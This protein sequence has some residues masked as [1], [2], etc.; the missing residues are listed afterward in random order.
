MNKKDDVIVKLMEKIQSLEE[1]L[2]Q[3]IQETKEKL[4][5]VQ[6]ICREE[7]TVACAQIT[8]KTQRDMEEQLQLVRQENTQTGLLV[9]TMMNEFQNVVKNE[10][11]DMKRGIK[12]TAQEMVKNMEEQGAAIRNEV[13]ST[14][15]ELKDEMATKMDEQAAEMTQKIKELQTDIQEAIN[16]APEPKEEITYSP[17]EVN[18]APHDIKTSQCAISS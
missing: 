1:K 13:Q 5:K 14:K 9:R 4:D 8:K 15:K 6:K 3:Q 16:P 7:A 12:Q 17:C 2:E 10:L 11:L 18:E